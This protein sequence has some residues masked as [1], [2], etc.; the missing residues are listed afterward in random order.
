VLITYSRPQ[1]L[2]PQQLDSEAPAPDLDPTGYECEAETVDVLGTPWSCTRRR[3]H[4]EDEHRAVFGQLGDGPA[5]AVAIAWAYEHGGAGYCPA[6][7]E[8]VHTITVTVTFPKSASTGVAADRIA[9]DVLSSFWEC[10]HDH[11]RVDV[12]SSTRTP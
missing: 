4:A 3:G 12:T 6:S 8:P 10:D 2:D 7:P 5:E 11:V 1:G 9:A